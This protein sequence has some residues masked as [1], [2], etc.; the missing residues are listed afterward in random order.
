VATIEIERA[1][2]KTPVGR[3]HYASAGEGDPVLFLHQTPRS[4]D[5]FRDVI[6]IVGAG[7][8]RAIAMDTIGYGDSDKP[9][10]PATLPLFG[11]GVIGLLDALGIDRAHL[12]GHHTGGV[13]AVE[14]A[15]SHPERVRKLVLSGTTCPDEEGRKREWPTIDEVVVRPDGS[16]LTELWQKREWFYPKDQPD[17]LTRFVIDALKR[18]LDR[19]EDGHTAVNRFHIEDRLPNIKGPVRLLCG[20]E[21]WAAKPD[22]EKLQRYLPQA[23]FVEVEGGMIP[24]DEQMP[25]TFAKLVLEFLDRG[26]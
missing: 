16:H 26:D 10:E 17:L 18:G 1:F 14:V 23:E 11:S 7:G 22:Q 24:L 2:A 13:V 20:S 8:Y 5:E 3:I 4:W 15:G 19:V 12:V 21:D 6:P 25:E 9:D